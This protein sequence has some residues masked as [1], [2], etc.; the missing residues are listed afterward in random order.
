MKKWNIPWNCKITT[1]AN[2]TE[3]ETANICIHICGGL[4]TEVVMYKH[5]QWS[6]ELLDFRMNANQGW[7][8]W[9][10]SAGRLSITSRVTIGAEKVGCISIWRSNN[11]FWQRTRN[12]KAASSFSATYFTLFQM[13]CPHSGVHVTLRNDQMC[14]LSL[15]WT[16]AEFLP[17]KQGVH[18]KSRE[19]PVILVHSCQALQ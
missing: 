14:R 15:H 12:E 7:R 11:Y 19:L 6:L 5:K 2:T 13:T 16:R 17:S 1:P 4:S 8:A 9:D 10:S 18:H 3:N